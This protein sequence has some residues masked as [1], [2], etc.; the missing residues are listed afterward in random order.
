MHWTFQDYLGQPTWFVD[1]LIE[2]INEE[3]MQARHAARQSR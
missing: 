2:R 3:S 1:K